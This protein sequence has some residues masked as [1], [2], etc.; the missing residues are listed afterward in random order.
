MASLSGH[1]DN[2]LLPTEDDYP[3]IN[4]ALTGKEFWRDGYNLL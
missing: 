2:E 1:P 3:V 4:R